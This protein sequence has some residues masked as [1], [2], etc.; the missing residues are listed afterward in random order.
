M[1]GYFFRCIYCDPIPSSKARKLL[2]R[3]GV[4]FLSYLQRNTYLVALPVGFKEERLARINARRVWRPTPFEKMNANLLEKPYGAWATEGEYLHL[5]IQVYPQLRI[6]Q[7]AARLRALGY[8]VVEEGNQNGFL[9]ICIPESDLEAVANLPFV[10]YLELMPPP[11]TPEDIQGRSMH[12]VSL[13]DMDSPLGRRYDGRGVAAVVRDDGPLGPHIDFQGRYTDWF[14]AE[15]GSD[16]IHGDGVAGILG[17]A[18][19]LNPLMRGMATGVYLYTVRYR[20]SFQDATL[21]LHTERG[22]TLTNTSYSDGCNR[23]YTLSAQTVERQ[24]YDFPYLMHVFSAGNEG[25]TDCNYG[26]GPGWGNITGGHKVAKNAIAVANLRADGTLMHTSS[27]GPVHDGRLKP[28][29]A[30]HGQG[31]TSTAPDHKYRT[32][33]GTSAAAPGVVGVLAQ[34]TQAFREH[35]AGEQPPAAL[36]KAA[37]LNTANDLGN[38]GPD[39][40]FGFGLVNAW[41]AYRLLTERRW[42]TAEVDHKGWIEHA[43]TIP[44]NVQQVRILL[45]WPDPPAEAGTQ[46]ALINDLDLRVMNPV[47]HVHLPLVLD[48]TPNPN[49]L[50][51]PAKPGRDS[52]NNVEEVTISNPAAGNYTVRIHGFEVPLGPQLYYLVWDFLYD[53]LKLIYPAGGEGLAPGDTCRIHWDAVGSAEPFS[54]QYSLDDGQTWLPI[55]TV[56]GDKRMHDWIVPKVVSAQVRVRVLRGHQHDMSELP[57]S[58]VPVPT[59]LKVERVCL[60]SATLSWAP[61]NDTL[62]YDVYLLGEKYMEIVSTTTV[63]WATIPITNVGQEMWF[64][65]RASNPSGLAGRRAV[66][67]SWKG[68]LLNCPQPHNLALNAILSPQ[69]SDIE[70]AVS[71]EPTLWPVRISISNEGTLPAEGAFAWYQLNQLPPV[72]TP[73]P[74]LLPGTTAEVVFSSPLVIAENGSYLLR[75]WTSLPGER[76]FFNDTISL[77]FQAAVEPLNQYFSEGFE[78]S[79][80]PPTAWTVVNP[81]DEVGWRRFSLAIG[82]NGQLTSAVFM[83]FYAYS[84]EKERDY[85]YLPPLDLSQLPSARLVFDWAY[86]PYDS[87]VSDSLVLEAFSECNLSRPVRLWAR[88]GSSLATHPTTT[89]SFSPAHS[90]HWQRASIPLDAFAGQRIIL[91]FTAVNDY[92][93]NLFLDNVGIIEKDTS[94]PYARILASV[95][96]LCRVI[97]TVWFRAAD[98]NKNHMYQWFFGAA[99]QP[100]AASGPG[101]HAVRF[102]LAGLHRVRLVVSHGNET[103]TAYYALFAFG[104]ASANFSWTASQNSVS[105]LNTSTMAEAFEWDF[106]DGNT[107]TA[108]NPLHTYALPGQYTVRLNAYNRCSPTPSVHAKTIALNFVGTQEPQEIELV[109]V[110]PNPNSGSFKVQI[111]TQR[112]TQVHLELLDPQGR[113]VE[114]RTE[115]LSAR[116]NIVSFD[117]SLPPGV[118]LLY[119]RTPTGMFIQRITITS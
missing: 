50:S 42:L 15:E 90:S 77:K 30:A 19:N 6:E 85:L 18:G 37:L 43:L 81:D 27:R 3:E 93:N 97:D 96:T 39:F 38:P 60:D 102:F 86:A 62:Q 58:I 14:S 107:S 110:L 29:L 32:F 51:A 57:L 11:S 73:L 52:I 2:E 94:R 80:F 59:G 67:I 98:E 106:G 64:S 114:K 35:F 41:R 109:Q 95:D 25:A 31:Q 36:L 23:G 99:A 88:G 101:P 79:V 113:V 103:D 61:I 4:Q 63:P 22:A 44:P 12:R 28:D 72:A 56:G 71:C 100:N 54:L 119:L 112:P 68:G 105:F 74:T 34:L 5:Y 66:A 24:L 89:S 40:Q 17:G 13:L 118:Y 20:S 104:T 82:S 108:V 69:K 45:Y 48:P 9:H 53:S 76:V 55:Q 92:G 78:A 70:A 47:G 49:A 111:A 91:R 10:R 83:N 84:A 1:N 115:N 117:R 33:G 46:R 7:A 87:L 65:V 75:V 116:Q 26:A 8:R 21:S 16:G